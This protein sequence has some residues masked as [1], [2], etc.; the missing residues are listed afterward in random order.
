MTRLGDLKPLKELDNQIQ[1]YNQ[2]VKLQNRMKDWK[3]FHKETLY[4]SHIIKWHHWKRMIY[5]FEDDY[6]LVEML[7]EQ[8]TDNIKLT[9]DDMALANHTW[10]RY[11]I[12]KEAKQY[13]WSLQRKS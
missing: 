5:T 8:I 4:K 12:T 1:T 2:L 6:K 10:K 9:V 13:L 11:E 7:M 3:E